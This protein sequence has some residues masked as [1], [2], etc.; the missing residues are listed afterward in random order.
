MEWW[1]EYELGGLE[2]GQAAPEKLKT[3]VADSKLVLTSARLR[4]QQTASMA[5]PHMSAVPDA[6][7]NEAP[8]PP[9]RWNFIRFKPRTWNKYA[10]A[11]WMLG[12]SLGDETAKE[13]NTRATEAATTLHAHAE[14]GK[15]YLAAHGWFNRMIRRELKTLGWTCTYN[16]GDSYWS[17]RVYEWQQ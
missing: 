4:A 13:A 12:H 6:L 5:A 11:A 1:A 14:V 2:D 3:A 15:V 10:R 9:P 16:G 8:L 17:F 7:Y